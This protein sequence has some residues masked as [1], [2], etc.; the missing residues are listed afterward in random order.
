MNF[1]G[2]VAV[3]TGAASAIGAATAKQLTEQ[4]ARVVVV[5]RND[6]EGQRVAT[7]LN[8][9][10]F[11]GSAS[12]QASDKSAVRWERRWSPTAV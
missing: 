4:G 12:F 5:D 9:R 1:P 8:K 7:E 2:K 6:K 10:G 3:V 11:S